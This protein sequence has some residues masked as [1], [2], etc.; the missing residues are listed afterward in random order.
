MFEF[1]SAAFK[2]AHCLSSRCAV[3]AATNALLQC[4]CS[5]A[6]QNSSSSR[7]KFARALSLGIPATLRRACSPRVYV[8]AT[9]PSV[10]IQYISTREGES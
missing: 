9:T 1:T 6:K 8:Q 10:F 4:W 5:R 3:L 2:R 7:T